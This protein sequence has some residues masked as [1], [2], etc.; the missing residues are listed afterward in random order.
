MALELSSYDLL[1]QSMPSFARG[2]AAALIATVSCYPLDTVRRHIQVQA[3]RSVAYHTA[4][5][6]I[7]RDDGLRGMYRGFLPNALK[8]LPNKGEL[9]AFRGRGRLAPCQHIR[10]CFPAV[11][12]YSIVLHTPGEQAVTKGMALPTRHPSHP[13]TCHC[14]SAGVKLSV[15]DGAKKVLTVA[16]KAYDEECVAMGVVPPTRQDWRPAGKARKAGQQQPQQP[17]K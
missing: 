12:H 4:A 1:P 9:H 8:N 16:E 5:A 15:F 6:A 10:S 11:H 17:R 14:L 3:G 13:L 2:F 7:L